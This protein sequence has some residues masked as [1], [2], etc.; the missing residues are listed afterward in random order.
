ME[1]AHDQQ[2]KQIV[3]RARDQREKEKAWSGGPHLSARDR[4]FFTCAQSRHAFVPL[5]TPHLSFF[6]APP[7]M[8]AQSAGQSLLAILS[9]VP[10][11]QQ[12]KE[13]PWCGLV[14]SKKK[15]RRGAGS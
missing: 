14:S 9:H 1:R 13:K 12:E 10:H 8:P 7:Q 5:H 2:A 3:E 15:K 4:P 6:A 11:L